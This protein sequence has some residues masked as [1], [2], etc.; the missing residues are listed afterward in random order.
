MKEFQALYDEVK[1]LHENND[2]LK[3]FISFP[4][5]IVPK[6]IK[7]HWVPAADVLMAEK[8]LN[9]EHFENFRDALIDASPHMM[10]RETYKGTEIDSN[11]LDRF[12]CY[13]IIGRDAPFGSKQMRSFV[14]YQPPGFY[15]PFHEH[16]AEEIYIMLA[17]DC[18]WKKGDHKYQS[19]TVGEKS[20]HPSFLPHASKTEANAFMSVYVWYGDLSNDSYSYQ[21]LPED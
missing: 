21:G 4:S 2:G 14:V 15:Y 19:L 18:L 20:H 1:L 9:T 5:D 11:F 3:D 7:A 12:A 17:G 10:W 8:G 13:E 16:P 6:E